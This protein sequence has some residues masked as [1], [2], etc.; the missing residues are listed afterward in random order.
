MGARPV[1]KR[2]LEGEQFSLPIRGPFSLG[3]SARFLV[4]WP[5][6]EAFA[7]GSGEELRLAFAT[8]GFDG[9][10]AV[11]VRQEG[12]FLRGEMVG[13]GDVVGVEGQVARVLSLDHD[14]SDYPRVTERDPVIARLP[15]ERPGFRPVLFPSPYEAAAWAII[16]ARLP[17][18]QALATR[19]RLSREC[20]AVLEI[21]GAEMSAFPLPQRLLQIEAF[22]GLPDEKLRRLRGVAK[23]ALAGRLDADQLGA[24]PRE[25][26]LAGLGE[27]RGIGPFY[28]TLIL[29]RSTGVRDELPTGDARLRSLVQRA[30]GLADPPDEAE[31][32]AIAD[33]WRPY[34]TWVTTLLRASE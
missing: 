4:G 25:Q 9:H 26:A 33:G 15:Q 1:V 13:P 6:A 32:A 22:P 17:P 18:R 16:S 14:A 3:E 31:L 19:E 5:P 12:A 24:M 23:A 21:A 2:T 7:R 28:A 29:L 20:G 10:A 27:L 34:R 30:Y 8:D 11:H